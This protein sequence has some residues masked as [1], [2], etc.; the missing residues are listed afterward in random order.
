MPQKKLIAQ[1]G[2]RIKITKEGEAY[3]GLM[4][5]R[6]GSENFVTLKLDNGYNVGI[7]LKG[8][9][10]ELVENQ[11]FSL[12]KKR[13]EIVSP[14]AK[15]TRHLCISKEQAEMQIPKETKNLKTKIFNNSLPT[16]SLLG[17]GGTIVS[18][19]EY[20]TGAVFPA[21]EQSDILKL[22]PRLEEFTNIKP[23]KLF[24]L[25]SEDMHPSHWEIVAKEVAAEING[26]SQGIVLMHG[27]DTMHY[28]SA[29][30]SFMLQDLPVPVVL[31]GAQRSS[32]RGSS[33]NLQNLMCAARTALSDIA[34]VSICMHANSSDD[35]CF[36]HQGTKV[37]KMHT[38]RRDAF[39]SINALP[40]AKVWVDGKTEY[41]RKDYNKRGNKKLKLDYK[42][43][44]NVC[45]IQ[46]Y[47]GIKPEFIKNLSN[48]D[49]IVIGT[50]GIGN[51]P[52]NPSG[53]K[54]AKSIIPAI[55]SL[56][57][58]GIPVI[59]A[60]QTI[61]GRIQS[62][63]YTAGR[64]LEEAGAIGNY[65]DWTPETALVKLMWT[66]A[67]TKD[68]EK[69]KQIMLTNIAGEITERTLPETFLY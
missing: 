13:F 28:T 25:L 22:F 1:V 46:T 5:P 65:C 50:T 36:V 56:T 30:L 39:R 4:M 69:I 3:E 11:P 31:V 55:K 32:D 34:N 17:C 21:F 19:V 53:D 15:N 9:K 6:V 64:M 38:S 37:R 44:P 63:V 42:M 12:E 68:M 47:P 45:L 29:A 51:V 35:Y 66:L 59:M 43:N 24:D 20:K 18:R 67:K 48:F 2:D 33:D 62:N 61:Y 16:I 41:L 27:T 58:S 57:N 10:I 23:R 40:F 60:P 8:A 26:G 7:E 54:L 14:I 52:A 49:G